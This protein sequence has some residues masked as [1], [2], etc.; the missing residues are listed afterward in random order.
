MRSRRTKKPSVSVLR[1]CITVAGAN[2]PDA[3]LVLNRTN[4]YRARHQVGPLVWDDAL[5]AGSAAYAKVLAKACVLQH[6]DTKTYGENLMMV[7]QLPKPDNTCSIGIHSWY[8]EVKNY[9]FNTQRVRGPG[10]ACTCRAFRSLAGYSGIRSGWV[11]LR[12]AR[13]LT[14]ASIAQE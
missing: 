10:K 2:C 12:W 4:F 5:A 8:G 3:A 13:S 6:S 9:I 7:Q 11:R 1:A 14:H